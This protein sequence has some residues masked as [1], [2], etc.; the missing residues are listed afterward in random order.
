MA[1]LNKPT[2]IRE[3]SSDSLKAAVFANRQDMGK[4]AAMHVASILQELQVDRDEIRIVVG[5]AP[6]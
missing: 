3:F 5:S 1:Q 6:H 2:P 4:A